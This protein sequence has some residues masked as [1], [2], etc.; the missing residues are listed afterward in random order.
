MKR[1]IKF[2]A[3]DEADKKMLEWGL[4]MQTALNRGDVP[5][6]P[7]MLYRVI[8]DPR[9]IKMQFTGLRD[10]NGKEIYEGDVCT[11]RMVGIETHIEILNAQVS[12]YKAA[13]GFG[14]EVIG[15]DSDYRLFGFNDRNI[16]SVEV[17][18]NI[19]EN[20]E[21]LRSASGIEAD[22]Q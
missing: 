4:I 20:P 10:K 21:L 3:W 2:R 12:H 1:E 15:N 8:T 18:G 16:L 14:F 13:A 7:G 5:G 19:H 9:F 17:I 22:T 6:W 11:C